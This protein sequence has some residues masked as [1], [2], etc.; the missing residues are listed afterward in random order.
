FVEDRKNC[1]IWSFRKQ[2]TS[3]QMISFQS[4]IA[5]AIR[6]VFELE[7]SELT[8]VPLPD[9]ENRKHLL[10]YESSEGGAGVLRQLVR[11]PEL[12]TEVV[13]TTMEVCHSD[14]DGKDLEPDCEA[15]CYQCLMSYSNQMD[16]DQLDRRAILEMLQNLRR[17]RLKISPS[18]MSRDAHFRKLMEDS[19]PA[20]ELEREWLQFLYD[21]DFALPDD[22]QHEI[23]ACHVRADF[24]CH[25]RNRR[26][27]IFIDGSVH[28][29]PTRKEM[30]ARQEESLT[31]LGWTVIRFRHDN[32]SEWLNIIRKY[33]G[34]FGEGRKDIH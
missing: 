22:A 24:A 17:C 3:V 13:N 5:N 21:H 8:V 10:F 6:R 23:P 2:P 12:F 7:E 31:D 14:P 32:R 20:S 19:D 33:A 18:G 25:D 28:D 15:A 34:I 16:H 29:T 1:L 30:D 27:L 26:C 4:A 11:Q 9:E